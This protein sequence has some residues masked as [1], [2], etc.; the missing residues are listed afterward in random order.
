[1]KKRILSTLLAMCMV[2]A[3]LP[4]RVLAVEELPKLAAPTELSWGLDHSYTNAEG[5]VPTERPGMITWKANVPQQG[6]FVVKVYHLEKDTYLRFTRNQAKTGY[7][8]VE[9]FIRSAPE[10]GTYYFTVQAVGDNVNYANSDIVCSENFEYKRPDTVLNAPSN[11]R[12][13]GM[14]GAFK[15]PADTAGIAGYYMNFAFSETEDGEKIFL[16]NTRNSYVDRGEQKILDTFIQKMG[17][18]YYWFRLRSVPY[19]ITKF[20]LSPW[21]EYSPAFHLTT[22]DTKGSLDA[23]TATA[24]EEVRS[25]VQAMGSEPLKAAMLADPE[26]V[27][28]LAEQEEKLGSASVDVSSA[29]ENM[30]TE[31]AKVVGAMLNDVIGDVALKVSTPSKNDLVVPEA[32]KNSTLN[33]K[34]S[35]DLE[36][37]QDPEH[38]KVPVQVTLPIPQGVN[39]DF[40]HIVHYHAN[41]GYD[42]LSNDELGVSSDGK[43]VS[44]VLTSFSD[45]MMVETRSGAEPTPTPTPAPPA[46]DNDDSGDDDDYTPPSS[47]S[48]SSSKPKPSPSAS[49]SPSP[50]PTPTPSPAPAPSSTPVAKR[51][52]DISA[53]DWFTSAVQYV[54]DKGLM[55]G[56]DTDEF[57]PNADMTRAMLMT[58]LA[59]LDGQDT[60]GGDIWYAKAMDWA[61]KAGIS[62]GTMPEN[63]VT[64]EQMVTMLYRYAKV[65]KVNGDLSRFADG[66]NVSS[67]AT[68]AM[69]WAVNQGILTGKDDGRLDPQ[70]TATRAEVATIL[71]RF[72]EKIGK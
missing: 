10:D 9:Y 46:D 5:G 61:K 45:F 62:D 25:Q 70:G 55:T 37:V 24:P 43:F 19:D 14:K 56:T 20:Q 16:G 3:P 21:T 47:S 29:P 17:E 59:R 34:F 57:S 2:L 8:S 15:K 31:G 39:P 13:N 27:K 72:V 63:S 42:I 51:F 26:V 11:L 65:N 60:A 18:G 38:L 49:P 48:S 58:V 50:S 4:T 64:R 35:M 54:C 23:I 40:L 53:N 33:V 30:P 68:E 6:N 44:F 28:K 22:T 12:W 1:M 66:K 7:N 52:S 69:G 36:G 32:L 67:W 71:Q 41:G